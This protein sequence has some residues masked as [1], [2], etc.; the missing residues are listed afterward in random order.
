MFS[1]ALQG[2]AYL[3]IEFPDVASAE[4][5]PTPGWVLTDVTRDLRFKNS[6]LA[7]DGMPG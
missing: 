4:N 2:L 5:Y 1:G 6:A 7:Q 3:E